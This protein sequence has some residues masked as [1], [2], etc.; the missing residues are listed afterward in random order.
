MLP[1]SISSR[2]VAVWPLLA[3]VAGIAAGIA[4]GNWQ[5]SRAAEK[6]DARARLES[7]SVQPPIQVSGVELAASDVE[8]R[9]VEARGMFDSRNT[10]YIDN[11]IHRGVPGYHV[12]TPLELEGGARHV[13]VNRGWIARGADRGKLPEV[14]TPSVAVSVSG[15]ATVPGKRTLE[16]SEH[17]V[18]GRIWQNLTIE[19]YREAHAAAI[20]PFVIQ[21][22]S[23]AQDGLVREWQAPDFGID[24][25]YGYA[26]QWYALAAAI[27]VFYGVTR[28]RRKPEA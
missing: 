20:Q 2:R 12:V 6:R 28:Y 21:Q 27:L 19:R 3:A 4:L 23:A 26:F 11:R 10:V 5:L 13:L 16:L 15:L 1:P 18:E 22:E 17:V 8:S 14:P 24:R 25:H 7:L 9:R